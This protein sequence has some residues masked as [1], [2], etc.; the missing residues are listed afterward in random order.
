MIEAKAMHGKEETYDILIRLSDVSA[1][2]EEPAQYPDFAIKYKVALNN[3]NT[4]TFNK[5]EGDKIYTAYKAHLRG[6]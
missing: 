4:F 2:Y 6:E 5:E 1:V 3:G